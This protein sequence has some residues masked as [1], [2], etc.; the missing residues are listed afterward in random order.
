MT[1]PLVFSTIRIKVTEP[2]VDT[3]TV[4]SLEAAM[5]ECVS[6]S[7]L[8]SRLRLRMCRISFDFVV[9]RGEGL[10][11]QRPRSAHKHTQN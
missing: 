6:D 8:K 1:F 3:S 10:Y 2:L 5:N 9:F 4:I 7:S 11:L